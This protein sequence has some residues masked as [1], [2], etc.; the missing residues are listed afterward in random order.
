[1]A[2][3]NSEFLNLEIDKLYTFDPFRGLFLKEYKYGDTREMDKATGL[4]YEG[5]YSRCKNTI[6]SCQ[7]SLLNADV[8]RRDHTL[9]QCQLTQV[10]RQPSSRDCLPREDVH[11]T[12]ARSPQ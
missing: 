6:S 1:M 11:G 3:R 8:F 10:K 9:S 4:L 2:T 12:E 5:P 7:D